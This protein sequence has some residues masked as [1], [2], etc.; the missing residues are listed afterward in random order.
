M[1]RLT[2]YVCGLAHNVDRLEAEYAEVRDRGWIAVDLGGI[3]VHELLGDLRAG[4]VCPG[5]NRRLG[6]EVCLS[7]LEAMRRAGW[8]T[9]VQTRIRARVVSRWVLVPG[10]K[11]PDAPEPFAESPPAWLADLRPKCLEATRSAP[12]DSGP[13]E[14]RLTLDT[15]KLR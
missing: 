14:F 5:A 15:R 4:P 2:P 9:C 8:V 6:A 1:S 11:I 7:I 13:L 3:L 12:R 10:A